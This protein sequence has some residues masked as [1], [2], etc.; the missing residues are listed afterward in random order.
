MIQNDLS[1]KEEEEQWAWFSSMKN[2]ASAVKSAW[3]PALSGPC[4]IMMIRKPPSSVTCA[5]IAFG[6]MKS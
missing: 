3:R 4:S 6:K 5:L 1:D 2:C